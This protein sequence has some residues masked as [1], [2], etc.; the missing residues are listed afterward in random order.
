ME[1]AADVTLASANFSPGSDSEAFLWPMGG[2][3]VRAGTIT[4]DAV[5]DYWWDVDGVQRSAKVPVTVKGPRE[6]AKVNFDEGD[7]TGTVSNANAKVYSST[8]P[9][10]IEVIAEAGVTLEG[11]MN[12]ADDILF[13]IVGG[14]AT[15]DSF[16]LKQAAT[17]AGNQ[18]E[19]ASTL[20]GSWT[21]AAANEQVRVAV[22]VVTG[23][24]LWTVRFLRV[25]RV[26]AP[27]KQWTPALLA[28]RNIFDSAFWGGPK[29][30]AGTVS[31]KA[32]VQAAYSGT[33]LCSDR[34]AD[35][36]QRI[37]DTG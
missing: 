11:E 18:F 4:E 16:D 25:Y 17:G 13:Q 9:I 10:G 15:R 8:L 22:T 23:A 31:L 20:R 24:A 26:V 29:S 12:V 28:S 36:D 33:V 34:F 37:R 30:A 6:I 14:A 3:N 2:F 21:T 5:V 19:L 7:V 32:R 27:V 35:L 1:N